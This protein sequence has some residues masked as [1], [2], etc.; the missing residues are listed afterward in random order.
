[1]AK[2]IETAATVPCG[3]VSRALNGCSGSPETTIRWMGVGRVVEVEVGWPMPR[4]ASSAE[5]MIGGLAGAAV[6]RSGSADLMSR[7]VETAGTIL[8]VEVT[9][10]PLWVEAAQGGEAQGGEAPWAKVGLARTRH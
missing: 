2:Q 7:Q 5:K 6:A 4:V 8:R 10:T 9:V 3:M 1:M